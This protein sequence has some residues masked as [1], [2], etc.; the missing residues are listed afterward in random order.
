MRPLNMNL[1]DYISG[2]NDWKIFSFANRARRIFW[3]EAVS[4]SLSL[5]LVIIKPPRALAPNWTQRDGVF[6]AV[7]SLRAGFP[8]SRKLAVDDAT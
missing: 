2:E 7:L 5:S 6:G 1:G 8:S 4:S 3:R